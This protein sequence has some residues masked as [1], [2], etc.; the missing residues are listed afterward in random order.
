MA[1]LYEYMNNIDDKQS[2]KESFRMTPDLWAEIKEFVDNPKTTGRRFAYEGPYKYELDM[3]YKDALDH[4]N[5]RH[6]DTLAYNVNHSY[7][8]GTCDLIRKNGEYVEIDFP[9]ECDYLLNMARQA[10]SYKEFMRM[11]YQYITQMAKL[12]GPGPEYD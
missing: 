9:A 6:N 2:L 10:N 11:L 5:K 7:G 12:V 8:Y 4:Y 1:N 3:M